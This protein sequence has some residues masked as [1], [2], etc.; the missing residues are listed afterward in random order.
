MSGGKGVV[1]ARRSGAGDATVLRLL[2][3]EGGPQADARGQC[4][5][6]SRHC[7][8]GSSH[9]VRLGLAHAVGMG[10]SRGSPPARPIDFED[11]HS[12]SPRWCP[13]AARRDDFH[14]ALR[15][16]AVRVGSAERVRTRTARG[17]KTARSVGLRHVH[18][19]G[20]SPGL[21]NFSRAPGAACGAAHYVRASAVDRAV[22]V[23]RRARFRRPVDERRGSLSASGA[24]GVVLARQWLAGG[25]PARHGRWRRPGHH[26][27]RLELQGALLMAVGQLARAGPAAPRRKAARASWPV[28]PRWRWS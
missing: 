4:G 24:V 21:T 8:R 14:H 22:D 23:R 3:A 19:P 5:R 15:A 6:C 18:V 27:E 2:G 20:R 17:W 9:R 11:F 10:S 12:A 13:T 26:R 1:A 16:C 25:P 7:R 28:R